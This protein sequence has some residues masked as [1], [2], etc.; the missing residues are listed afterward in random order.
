MSNARGVALR[1]P[2]TR[3]SAHYGSDAPYTEV[4]YE[5]ERKPTFCGS[6]GGAVFGVF[7]LF[8]ATVLLW[9]NEGSAVAASR[10][11]LEAQ[12]QLATGGISH[13]SGPLK[14]D[15]LVRDDDYGVESSCIWLERTPEVY[16]YKEVEHKQS[17]KVP[18][19]KGGQL[20]ETTRTY[21]YPT[22]W[23]SREIR[24]SEFKDRRAHRDNPPWDEVAR[25]FKADLGR[26]FTKQ[27]WSRPVTLDGLR[28]DSMLL[29]QAEAPVSVGR[30]VYA[31]GCDHGD[32]AVGCGRLSWRHAPLGEVSVLGRRTLDGLAP[33]KASGGGYELGLL[34]RGAHSAEAM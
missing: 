30:P 2:A 15:G 33:W 12:D 18:D 24:S 31:P 11:L 1:R 25:D 8:G 6:L 34:M 19:G 9:T 32:P 22:E 29:A 5:R 20:T 4:T 23:S 7:L 16:Q 26:P 13:V 3:G 17:R 14:S 27:R 10:G 28:L 21:T